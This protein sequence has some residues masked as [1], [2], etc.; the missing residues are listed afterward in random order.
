[1][2]GVITADVLLVSVSG[3]ATITSLG[4]A[5]GLL[6][7][8]MVVA[9]VLILLLWVRCETDDPATIVCGTLGGLVGS[10]QTFDWDNAGSGDHFVHA[11][12]LE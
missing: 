8:A 1:M 4:V 11:V 2:V 6:A 9:A 7:L 12:I 3:V 10:R 5:T